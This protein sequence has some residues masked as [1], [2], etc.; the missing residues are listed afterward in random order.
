MDTIDKN[1]FLH[2]FGQLDK[3]I[4]KIDKH[5]EKT[6]DEIKEVRDSVIK[7]DLKD[8]IN[9]NNNNTKFLKRINKPQWIVAGAAFATLA[10]VLFNTSS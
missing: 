10:V 4:D 1:F 3:R 5:L 8:K 9:E 2:L 7:L 6:C